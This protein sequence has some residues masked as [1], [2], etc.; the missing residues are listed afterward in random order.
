MFW[1]NSILLHCV[2]S[3]VQKVSAKRVFMYVSFN[4]DIN[5]NFVETFQ[6][7]PWLKLVIKAL[8]FY[9]LAFEIFQYLLNL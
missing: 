8:Y 4:S 3:F 2:S 5:T 7:Y 1:M 6:I 9:C